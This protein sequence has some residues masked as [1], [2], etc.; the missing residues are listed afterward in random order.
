MNEVKMKPVIIIPPETVSPEDVALLREN[1]L[2]VVVA[3]DPAKV[4]FLDSVPV[5]AS[6]TEIEHAAIQ[7]SRRL[8]KGELVG[9]DYR[10]N[11]TALYVDLLV[12]GTPLDPDPPRA[13]REREIF[14]ATKADE[15]RRLA[16]EEAK[17]ERAA[18]KAKK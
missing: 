8:L 4:K 14:D 12:K 1:G 3:S 11:I 18:L 15:L 16:R 13:E 10:K 17:A 9:T 6:R 7:L 5:Q 2:C